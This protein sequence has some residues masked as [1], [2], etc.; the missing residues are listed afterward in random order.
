MS[1]IDHPANATSV[2]AR[3]SLR[4]L[5]VQELQV[6]L[7]HVRHRLSRDVTPNGQRHPSRQVAPTTTALRFREKAI[8]DEIAYRADAAT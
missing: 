4:S 7:S 1:T 8:V 6:E 5:S 3:W 2:N